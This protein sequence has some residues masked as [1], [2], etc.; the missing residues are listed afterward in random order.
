MVLMNIHTRESMI[1]SRRYIEVEEDRHFN[2]FRCNHVTWKR[3]NTR[4]SLR[5]YCSDIKA[6]NKHSL[7]AQLGLQAER[8]EVISRNLFTLCPKH[9][10]RQLRPCSPQR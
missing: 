10:D 2:T 3:R 7:R 9:A 6:K 4:N 5:H 1:H 8:V